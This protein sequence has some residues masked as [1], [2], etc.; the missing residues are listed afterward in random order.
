M[1]NFSCFFYQKR[2]K[3]YKIEKSYFF[4]IFFCWEASIYQISKISSNGL[5]FTIFFHF[6]S[7]LAV[8]WLFF[9]QKRPK[10]KKS[11]FVAFCFVTKHLYNKFLKMSSNGLDFANFLNFWSILA[12][13]WPKKGQNRQNLLNFLLLGSIYIPNFRKFIKRLGFCQL[14]SFCSILTVFVGQ[15]M[16][17]KAKIE[18]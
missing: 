7:T 14:F 2:P 17:K 9:N 12:V 13:F 11:F 8:F 16:S 1:V 6:W 10:S 15:K 3:N 5:D 18:Q 4:S